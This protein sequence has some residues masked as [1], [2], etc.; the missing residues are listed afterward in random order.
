MTL[1]S[2]IGNGYLD[3]NSLVCPK[4]DTGSNN[5]VMYSGE[6]LWLLVKNQEMRP[7]IVSQWAVILDRCFKEPGLLMRS[8]DNAGGQEGPDDY[9]GVCLA[10]KAM[11]EG[12]K[13]KPYS[14]A[15]GNHILRYGLKHFGFFRNDP[16]ASTFGPFLWRQP[17]LIAAAFSVAVG[18]WYSRLLYF[19]LSRPFMWY[20]AAVIFFACRGKF[21]GTDPWRLTWIL[22]QLTEDK[23]WLCKWAVKGWYYR[24]ACRFGYPGMCLVARDYYEPDH[25]FATYHERADRTYLG[26]RS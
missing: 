16:G 2:R 10:A 19:I 5:G 6:F 21:D 9:L 12:I 17:Q 24:L 3:K 26:D 8:P 11:N 20:T 25:P 1:K 7:E 13:G 18:P 4:R 15:I 23:S 14:V 22:I